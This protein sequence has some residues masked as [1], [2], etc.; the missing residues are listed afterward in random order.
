MLVSLFD[1]LASPSDAEY[2][3]PNEI[4]SHLWV[5]R[6][7]R[8]SVI[9]GWAL[10]VSPFVPCSPCCDRDAMRL[11]AV[12]LGFGDVILNKFECSHSFRV[13]AS[14]SWRSFD[15][16][17]VI[18]MAAVYDYFVFTL[19]VLLAAT[20]VSGVVV[21]VWFFPVP[22]PRLSVLCVRRYFAGCD[23]RGCLVLWLSG[24]VPGLFS[25]TYSNSQDV[26]EDTRRKAKLPSVRVYSVSQ[27]HE[28]MGAARVERAFV[29]VFAQVMNLSAAAAY[30]AMAFMFLGTVE[31]GS[32]SAAALDGDFASVFFYS[33]LEAVDVVVLREPDSRGAAAL[34]GALCQGCFYSLLGDADKLTTGGKFS[35]AAAV[36]KD[37]IVLGERDSVLDDGWEVGHNVASCRTGGTGVQASGRVG[38]PGGVPQRAAES[39]CF[40]H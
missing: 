2:S 22:R 9:H 36:L 40:W 24:N 7:I 1:H 19:A 28:S 32:S 33:V 16:D 34:F 11:H 18:W 23:Y 4:A 5:W 30:V 35:S 26:N 37:D 3:R 27:V 39:S 38:V 15:R 31:A 21:P 12:S 13:Q 20:I 29:G 17:S 8:F 14:G 6:E 25:H 10:L